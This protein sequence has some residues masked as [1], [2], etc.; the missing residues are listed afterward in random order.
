MPQK[1]ILYPVGTRVTIV[2]NLGYN[3]DDRNIGKSAEVIGYTKLTDNPHY[4]R[5][6]PFQY[7]IRIDDGEET[8]ANVKE[9]TREIKQAPM[10]GP[11]P[12]P[13][14]QDVECSICRPQVQTTTAQDTM[15]ISREDLRTLIEQEVSRKLSIEATKLN[16][17]NA[18]KAAEKEDT[19]MSLN[20][21]SLT[22]RQKVKYFALPKDEKILRE[23]GFHDG[24]GALTEQGR[25]I[26]V[27]V[28]WESLSAADRKKVVEAVAATLPKEK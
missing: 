18:A 21:E 22:L 28:L 12:T 13:E 2:K 6:L 15:S 11:E 24:S 26:V 5:G 7:L 4:C 10:R 14:C 27:D 9:L 19:T 20:N 16:K 23:S 17:L 1:K 25:R 3:Y 8:N